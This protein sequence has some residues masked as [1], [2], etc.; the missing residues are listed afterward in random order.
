MVSEDLYLKT[1]GEIEQLVET[2]DRS[3]KEKDFELWASYLSSAYAKRTAGEDFL[4]RASQSA[5]LRRNGITLRSLKDYFLY[6]VVPSRSQARLDDILFVDETH[7]KAIA[8][9][10]DQ[11]V[12][13]YWLVKSDARWKI[14]IW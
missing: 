4:L 13:L 2:L 12:I 6:V 8:R 3:I 9:V 1:F 5:V 11:P 10:N 14:G 7:V